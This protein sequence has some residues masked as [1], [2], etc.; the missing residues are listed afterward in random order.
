MPGL[1]EIYDADLANE[2]LTRVTRGYEGGVPEHPELET[3]NE[4]RYARVSDGSLSPSF[5][6]AGQMLAFSSTASN[7]VFGDGNAPPNGQG[8]L[9]GADVFL[10]PRIVFSDRTHAADDLARA[11]EP[12]PR[13]AV[14]SGGQR[15]VARRAGKCS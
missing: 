8:E 11:R 4:D 3:G 5:D 10:V 14:A 7:L 1:V 15:H 2:T 13:T 12:V 9:D 6:A